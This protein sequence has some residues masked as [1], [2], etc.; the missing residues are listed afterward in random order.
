[1]TAVSSVPD[2]KEPRSQDAPSRLSSRVLLF[3]R[4]NL[5]DMEILM[6]IEDERRGL[7]S[8]NGVLAEQILVG[9]Y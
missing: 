5:G 9:Q 6:P 1:M 3:D 2:A 7:K 4:D 8:L